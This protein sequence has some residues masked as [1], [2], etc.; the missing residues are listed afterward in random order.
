MKTFYINVLLLRY[1][2]DLSIPER[3]YLLYSFL[4]LHIISLTGY[5]II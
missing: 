4:K 5:V 3:K 2:G 1:L